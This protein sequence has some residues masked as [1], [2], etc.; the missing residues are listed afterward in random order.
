MICPLPAAVLL[1]LLLL[2]C[3]SMLIGYW[4]GGGCSLAV[5]CHCSH[6]QD[7]KRVLTGH[8]LRQLR[9]VHIFELGPWLRSLSSP[10]SSSTPLAVAVSAPR[11]S[12]PPTSTH[13]T[14]PLAPW[15]RASTCTACGLKGDHAPEARD[16]PCMS[17]GVDALADALLVGGPVCRSPCAA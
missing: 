12:L 4:S 2:Y 15:C 6:Q 14:L 16:I 9:L 1:L 3:L 11:S 7:V 17:I 10:S 13:A 5:V 8:C